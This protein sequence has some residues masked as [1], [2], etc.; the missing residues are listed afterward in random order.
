MSRRMDRE[1]M[2]R[3][4]PQGIKNQRFWD[5]P[6]C[7]EDAKGWVRPFAN[8]QGWEE[9]NRAAYALRCVLIWKTIPLPPNGPLLREDGSLDRDQLYRGSTIARIE[10]DLRTFKFAIA[11][12]KSCDRP[13]LP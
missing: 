5:D 12:S 6:R 11:R 9:F 10:S 13:M 8:W 3:M 1:G 2:Y 4:Q 7:V